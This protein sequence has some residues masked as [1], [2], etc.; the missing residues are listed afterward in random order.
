MKKTTIL[1]KIA[2]LETIND[3]LLAELGYADHLMR[4]VGFSCGLQTVKATARELHNVD[5]RNSENTERN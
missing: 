2:E 1:K 4:L 3:H 5:T